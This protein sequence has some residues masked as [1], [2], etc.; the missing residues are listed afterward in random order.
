LTVDVPTVQLHNGVHMPQL[1]FGTSQV[2]DAQAVDVVGA[3][4]EAG[5]RSIDTA[6]IHGNERGVGEAVA[7]SG[8]PRHELFVTTK[9]WNTAQG[10]DTALRAFDESLARLGLEYVDLYLIHWPAPARDEYVQTW[11]AL[12][13][14][15][16]DG[17]A[18][19]IGVSNFHIPHLR[20]LS[21]ETST[22]PAVNQIELHPMLIQ[23]N[24]RAYHSE[25]G[26]ATEACSPLA[27][28]R[29]V[30]DDQIGYMA[31]KYGKTP[32]Q[33]ILRW[34]LDLGHVIIPKSATP[35]RIRENLEVFDF[36]LAEDDLLTLSEMDD[37]TRI[38]PNPDTFS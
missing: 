15:A 17:R 9:L 16:A 38:G 5:Y 21:E 32:A 14:L 2:R 19:A 31:Q 10:Y 4:I 24:L 23:S 30:H 11:K 35:V 13:K 26:I 6:A 25:H 7:R 34:H 28:G 12:E 3:A 37:G 29:L 20:R 18:R 22:L 33:V 27:G 36:E 1:G 8:V